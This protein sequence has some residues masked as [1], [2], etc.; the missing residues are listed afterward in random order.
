MNLSRMKSI[1]TLIVALLIGLY[2]CNGKP[3]TVHVDEFGFRIVIPPNYAPVDE[4]E[5]NEKQE[6]GVTVIENALETE[7][8]I[9]TV[10]LFSFSDGKQNVI[11]AMWQPWDEDVDGDYLEGWSEGNPLLYQIYSTQ[12]SDAKID[13]LTKTQKINGMDFQRVDVS[14]VFPNG[15]EMTTILISRLFDKRELSFSIVARDDYNRKV[16]LDAVSNVKF[17]TNTN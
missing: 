10:R 13:T 3:K 8:P 9:E 5:Y 1:N 4:D 16:L 7:V 6:K 17:D 2:S 14:V 15:N 11:D 12:F